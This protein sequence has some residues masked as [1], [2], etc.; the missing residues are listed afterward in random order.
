MNKLYEAIQLALTNHGE[1]LD[2]GGMLYI[3]HPLRVM[4]RFISSPEIYQ[5]VAVLHDTVEDTDVTLDDIDKQF[6]KEVRDA[7]DALSRRDGEP[8]I[9]FIRRGALNKTARAVKLSDLLD[10]SNPDRGYKNEGLL[11]RYEKAYNYLLET[12]F[13]ESDEE[14]FTFLESKGLFCLANTE[15]YEMPIL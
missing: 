14:E 3:T 9:D 10:N 1:Q 11:K 2:K 4:A 7:V 13:L 15:D 12:I 5:I 6:G 8:Y